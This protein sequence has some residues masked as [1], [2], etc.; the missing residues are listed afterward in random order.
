MK[1]RINK[2][3]K[4][5]ELI[6]VSFI[7]LKNV[8]ELKSLFDKRKPS[9]CQISRQYVIKL[10]GRIIGYTT[11]DFLKSKEDDLGEGAVA[12]YDMRIIPKHDQENNILMVLES[13]E[14]VCRKENKKKIIIRIDFY[15]FLSIKKLNSFVEIRLNHGYGFSGCESNLFLS[16]NI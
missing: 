6:E 4:T 8:K 7:D 11:L 3:E 12:I 10:E 5:I 13:I 2:L 15:H 16:K 9:A 14:N 1:V